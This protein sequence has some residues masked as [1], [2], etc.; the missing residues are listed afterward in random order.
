MYDFEIELSP[1]GDSLVYLCCYTKGRRLTCGANQI[2]KLQAPTRCLFSF[3]HLKSHL[4]EHETTYDHF[5]KAALSKSSLRDGKLNF[6]PSFSNCNS[7]CV[8][9]HEHVSIREKIVSRLTKQG[10]GRT[11]S[12]TNGS[13]G[14]EFDP[15]NFARLIQ[16]A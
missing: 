15:E 3:S 5:W 12:G 4:C 14:N 1:P 13:S 11:A 6:P 8:P 9:S 10:P 16:D 2:N 7:G